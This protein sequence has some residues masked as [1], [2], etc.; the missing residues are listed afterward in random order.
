MAKPNYAFDKKQREL[1]K[2][3]QQEEK[4]LKKAARNPNPEPPPAK[5]SDP[6]A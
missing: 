1:K 3:K 2:A 4:R 5:P 6:T